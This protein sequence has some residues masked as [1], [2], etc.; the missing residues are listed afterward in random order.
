[1]NNPVKKV[2]SY[3]L[4]ILVLLFTVLALLGIW[5][6]IQFEFVLRKIFWSLMVIFGASAVVLFIFTVLISSSDQK[7]EDTG[8]QRKPTE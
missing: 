4:I 7:D 2:V 5:D 1:M 8:A 3:I 6:I